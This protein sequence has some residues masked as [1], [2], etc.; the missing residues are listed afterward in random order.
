MVAT[1]ASAVGSV[2]S[3]FRKFADNFDDDSKN[4]IYMVGLS[5]RTEA[6]RR[7]IIH[8]RQTL[9]P[10]EGDTLLGDLKGFLRTLKRL[11]RKFREHV[12]AEIEAYRERQRK[13]KDPFVKWLESPDQVEIKVLWNDGTD[14]RPLGFLKIDR[15]W[16]L[17]RLRPQ[18]FPRLL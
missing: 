8:M 12:F 15:G 14:E 10:S 4:Y 7:R 17:V 1:Y 9:K 3:R 2:A 5:D 11:L 6:F 18:K 13:A 16:P